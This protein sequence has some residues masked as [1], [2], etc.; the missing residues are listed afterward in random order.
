MTGCITRR[1]WLG[2]SPETVSATRGCD[3]AEDYFHKARVRDQIGL[4]F[5][6]AEPKIFNGGLR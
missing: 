6:S 2:R 1:R 4:I 3:L 5:C